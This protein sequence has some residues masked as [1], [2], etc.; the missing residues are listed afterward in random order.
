[1]AEVRAWKPDFRYYEKLVGIECARRSDVDRLIGT[2]R[3]DLRTC[4]HEIIV[5]TVVV[6]EDAVCFLL[7]N[8]IQ[9]E[10]VELRHTMSLSDKVNRELSRRF[11]DPRDKQ[12]HYYTTG[13]GVHRTCCR[14]LVP[15]ATIREIEAVYA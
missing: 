1:M 15:I 10:K 5:N 11:S 12:P 13:K 7:L 9:H 8:D 6:P 4:P 2:L 14:Y 3:R